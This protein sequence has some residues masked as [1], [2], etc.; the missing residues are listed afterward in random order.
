MT[1]QVHTASIHKVGKYE[2]LGWFSE[3][4]R[5]WCKNKAAVIKNGIIVQVGIYG[6]VSLI[7]IADICRQ[8]NTKLYGIDPWEKLDNSNG[9]SLDDVASKQGVSAKDILTHYKKLRVN[10]EEIVAK[11]FSDVITLIQGFSPN[12]AAQFPNHSI[13]FVFIDGNHSYE[14]VK[15]D[16]NGWFSKIKKEK[17][18]IAGH[19]W[20]TLPV[21][22][23]VKEFCDINGLFYEA[24]NGLWEINRGTSE[25]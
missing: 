8:N 24:H 7:S 6:G 5:E 18:I 11:D 1:K 23:A 3:K 15:A 25:A 20:G 4:N 13:D 12:A 9:R 17:G 16:L 21:R 19:D 2:L 14:A 22:S 10:L